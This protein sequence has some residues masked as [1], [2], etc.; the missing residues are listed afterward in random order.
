[1]EQNE[2]MVRSG[3]EL[4]AS[5]SAAMAK[6][7]IECAYVMAYKRPRNYDDVRTKILTACKRPVFAESVEYSKPI[8]KKF[9]NGP[10]IRFVEVALQASGN[11][12]IN[13]QVLYEDDKIRKVMV[14]LTDLETNLPYSKEIAIEKTVERSYV[15]EGQTV[16][17][18]RINSSGKPTYLVAAT[19]DEML[20]KQ[21]SLESKTLR[22]LGLRV[23]P[24]DIVDE[25]MQTARE[26]RSKSAGDPLAAKNKIVDGFATLGIKPSELEKYLGKPL[27]QILPADLDNLR[28]IF[29][30]IRDGEAIWSDY[31]EDAEPKTDEKPLEEKPKSGLKDKLKETA[32]TAVKPEPEKPAEPE[33][34]NKPGPF[35]TKLL[36]FSKDIVRKA[37][38]ELKPD[39]KRG[40]EA[41][42]DEEQRRFIDVCEKIESSL[43]TSNGGDF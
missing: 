23:L 16:I 8:G 18:Q 10:S 3:T 7:E 20:V 31:L 43:Q 12:R 11:I 17:S 29:A 28:V 13:T 34:N 30:T 27:V 41:F 1:M 35:E 5:A 24:R 38:I 14:S 19:E 36:R 42:S 4:A 15:K 22:T 32:K 6:A 26:T 37:I 39:L 33:K 25:A 21:G 9:I 40:L 2:M